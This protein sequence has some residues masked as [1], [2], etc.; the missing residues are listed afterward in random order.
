MN[1][2]VAIAILLSSAAGNA[3]EQPRV[4]HLED[5]SKR[6]VPVNTVAPPYPAMARRDRIEGDVQVCFNVDRQGRP[7]RVAVRSSTNRVFE[8]PAIRAVRASRYRAL[9]EGEDL[10]GI[11]TC[12]TFRFRLEPVSGA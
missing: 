9:A 1:R 6:R 4:T 5:S 2:W 10:P 8:K 12:R 3:D 11:K 7:F